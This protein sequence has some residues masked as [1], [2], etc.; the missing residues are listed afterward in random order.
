MTW[1]IRHNPSLKSFFISTIQIQKSEPLPYFFVML[2]YP[3]KY[4]TFPTFPHRSGPT[5][6]FQNNLMGF[7]DFPQQVDWLKNRQIISS[8]FLLKVSGTWKIWDRHQ[9]ETMIGLTRNGLTMPDMPI[10]LD[11]ILTSLIF[12]GK[13]VL[14][15]WK[16]MNR[17]QSGPLFRKI[18]RCCRHRLQHFLS[19]NPT[20]RRESNVVSENAVSRR[21]RI[22]IAAATWWP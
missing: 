8:P 6:T 20:N 11:L 5:S 9:P 3:L 14:Q 1:T 10:M 17:K 7:L 16:D 12:I 4:M 15:K 21:Q 19:S 2:N 13:Q 22:T 18:Y